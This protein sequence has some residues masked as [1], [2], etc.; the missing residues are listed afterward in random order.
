M[1]SGSL[2]ADDLAWYSGADGWKPLSE[3]LNGAANDATPAPPPP[4]VKEEPKIRVNRG[5]QEIGPYTRETA[6]EYFSAGQLLPTDYAWNEATQAWAPLNQ[7]LGLPVPP[8][9]TPVAGKR[10]KGMNEGLKEILIWAGGSILVLFLGLLFGPE[11]FGKK[12]GGIFVFAYFFAI[13]VC[14]IMTIYFYFLLSWTLIQQDA[15]KGVLFFFL[16]PLGWLI[17][18]ID[19]ELWNENKRMCLIYLSLSVSISIML[20]LPMI[21]GIIAIALK[22][23]KIKIFWWN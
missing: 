10:S 8:G 18:L 13:L 21:V 23:A 11:L 17:F 1:E 16:H 15:L 12:V 3:V 20:L 7:V 9:M 22:I 4:P 5:G 19:R 14:G 6:V 2:K